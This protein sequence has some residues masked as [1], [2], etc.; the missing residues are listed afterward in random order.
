MD[1]NISAEESD[2]L[3]KALKD[4][5]FARL[6][7]EYAQEIS[8]PE[9]SPRRRPAR[10]CTCQRRA[11]A[12][13]EAYLRQLEAEGRAEEVYGSGVTLVA[14][15]PA[16]AIK[17]R[18]AGGG[19]KVFINVCTS[20]K[21]APPAR[22]VAEQDGRRGCFL[23][24]P[25]CVGAKPT[26]GRD[27]RG[28]PAAAW[29]FVVHPAAVEQARAAPGVMATLVK[30]AKEQVA[31]A[32]G[33]A[34]SP[35]HRVLRAQYKGLGG[36]T[37]PSTLALRPNG[38]EPAADGRVKPVAGAQ[39]WG[40]REMPGSA[41]AAAAGVQP[42]QQDG[43][44]AT[45]PGAEARRSAFA[46][47]AA[48]LACEQPPGDDGLRERGTRRLA[49]AAGA[50]PP[51]PRWELVHR[52]SPDLADT[53]ADARCGGGAQQRLPR[54]LVLRVELPGVAS[55][56]AIA[57]D[58][59]D[60]EVSLATTAAAAGGGGALRVKLPH[61]VDAS[62]CRARFDRRAQ[63]LEV[64][65]P[66]LRPAARP[67]QQPA[68]LQQGGGGGAEQGGAGGGAEDGGAE[69]GSAQEC[70][71]GRGPGAAEPE[72]RAQAA[73]AAEEEDAARTGPGDRASGGGAADG[74]AG[75]KG[76]KTHNQLL[77]EQL[78]PPVAAAAPAPPAQAPGSSHKGAPAAAPA[79]SAAAVRAPVAAMRPRILGGCVDEL[80]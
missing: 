77:W 54:E 28:D 63:R 70:G 35:Q 13:Q 50:A 12:E 43:G 78:H 23:E 51:Q 52:V 79:A 45:P 6:F 73:E 14:P 40:P 68:P 53:W 41:P 20:D 58:V 59:G 62:A 21:I 42:Q 3:L 25:N 75:G 69:E 38:A 34:L 29:D 24:V 8:N 26:E 49:P 33:A 67:P 11:K 27:R 10:I 4:P 57:L 31:K 61:A 71:E 1:R 80:D 46:F 16:F 39:C 37:G 36:A 5:E 32:A 19:A 9:A 15:S 64:V 44:A 60:T 65:M 48:A 30:V 72:A 74:A 56:D 2:K 7:Q 22:R 18:A 17:A 76:G 55:I 66:V 47:G